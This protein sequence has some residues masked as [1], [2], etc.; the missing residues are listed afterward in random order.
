MRDM[1]NLID[2]AGILY[3]DLSE[4]AAYDASLRH[5]ITTLESQ[6]AQLKEESIMLTQELEFA[7]GELEGL[8]C[9]LIAFKEDG[10]LPR[11]QALLEDKDAEIGELKTSLINRNMQMDS[12]E[13]D[14][15]ILAG[16]LKSFQA[17]L[18]YL[19]GLLHSWAELQDIT[20]QELLEDIQEC[21]RGG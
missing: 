11:L 14:V 1:T 2:I 7:E 3:N 12:L 17:E 9:D 5:Q 19:E 10:N 8:V 4:H 15:F 18:E 21:I 16:D 20:Y 6:V 13:A